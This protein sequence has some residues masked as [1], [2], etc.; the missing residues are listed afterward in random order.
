MTNHKI[1]Y[2]N[3]AFIHS[4]CC[5]THWELIYCL[6]TQQ[7]RMVCEQCGKPNNLEIKGSP[8]DCECGICKK[9]IEED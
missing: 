3:V 6:K 1:H 7:Y 2:D 4:K 9:R 8:I 5:M